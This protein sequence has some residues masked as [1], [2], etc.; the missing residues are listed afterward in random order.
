MASANGIRTH[1]APTIPTP[2][3][4]IKDFADPS[5]VQSLWAWTTG[6]SGAYKKD[7]MVRFYDASGN[8]AKKWRIYGCFP[9]K[10]EMR[11]SYSGGLELTSEIQCDRFDVI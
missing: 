3:F 5:V 6:S 10:S 11:D 8:V 2:I 1:Y 4:Y 7:G 9:T